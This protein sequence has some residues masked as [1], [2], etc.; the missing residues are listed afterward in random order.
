[1]TWPKPKEARAQAEGQTSR[2]ASF[3]ALLQQGI[4]AQVRSRPRSGRERGPHPGRTGPA[5]TA[6]SPRRAEDHRVDHR[7]DRPEADRADQP[8]PAPRGLP[9]T[10]RRLARVALSGQ[11]H[12]NRRDAEDPRD[13]HLQEGLAQDAEEVQGHRLGPE[14]DLQESL[15]RGVRP[16]RRR[17]LR[18]PGRRLPLRPQPA[19]RRVARRDGQGRRG[20]ARPVH[21]RE[22]RPA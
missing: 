12:R 5:G 2:A 15:R 1:V 8:D 3:A 4:Q 19:G 20:G 18:L 6:L 16:V 7:R 22:P 10:G 21:R 13:E 14:P 11:Q 9:A 17:A